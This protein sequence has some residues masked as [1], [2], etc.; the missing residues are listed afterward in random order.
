MRLSEFIEQYGDIEINQEQVDLMKPKSKWMPKRGQTYWFV[1]S[2]GCFEY[3]IWCDSDWDNYRRNFL[4]IFKT[5]TEVERY[6]GIMEYCQ[7]MSF[8]PNWDDEKQ[9]KYSIMINHNKVGIFSLSC[10]NYG[11]PF[12]FESKEKAQLAIDKFGDDLKK[13]LFGVE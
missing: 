12:Y 10:S 13:Y 3:Q 11:C 2:E 9:N 8:E 1:N 4:R 7:K 5:E 6:R